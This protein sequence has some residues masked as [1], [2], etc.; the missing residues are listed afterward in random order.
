[1]CIRDSCCI[2]AT[3]G[4]HQVSLAKESQ[5]LTTIITQA[6]RFFYTTLSQGITS[7]SDFW[8]KITDGE[9]RI[10]VELQIIKN[11]DDYLIGGETIQELEYKL[12]KLMKFFEKINLKLAP[13]VPRPWTV[14]ITCFWNPR[15]EESKHCSIWG[16]LKI[17]RIYKSLQGW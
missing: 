2:D 3:S 6:G 1:M 12:N 9:C 15:K 11:M 10:D 8:N 16:H 4:Y 17:K 13:S 7:S 5:P 14:V